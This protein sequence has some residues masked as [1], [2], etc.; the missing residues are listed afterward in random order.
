MKIELFFS[1]DNRQIE[2]GTQNFIGP[3]QY[4]AWVKLKPGR[5]AKSLASYATAADKLASM[6]P[7]RT[8][9][10]LTREDG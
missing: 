1:A 7:G 6:L 10:S 3:K 2:S 5:P 4:D 9:A 8:V